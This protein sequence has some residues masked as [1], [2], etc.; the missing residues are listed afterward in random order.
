MTD[1]TKQTVAGFCDY[2]TKI[3]YN[4][5]KGMDLEETTREI[6]EKF[7]KSYQETI[8]KI[9]ELSNE[10]SNLISLIKVFQAEYRK[11]K[12]DVVAELPDDESEQE[13]P[14]QVKNTDKA[15]EEDKKKPKEPKEAKEQKE[16]KEP[17]GRKKKDEIK[18]EVKEEKTE[19]KEEVKPEV[20]DEVKEDEKKKKIIKKKK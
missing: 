12:G 19:V 4:E 5:K 18:E 15:V 13:V 14:Q 17:R 16:Q 10:R 1:I 3:K 2:L 6:Q 9:L 7:N 8:A 20:K 11:A